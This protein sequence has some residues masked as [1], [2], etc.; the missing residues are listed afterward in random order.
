M[1]PKNHSWF[2]EKFN[3]IDKYL[4]RMTKKKEKIKMLKSGAKEE[5]QRHHYYPYRNK[6]DYRWK[7]YEQLYTNKL[8]NK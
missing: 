7:Y 8:D 1:D 4:A 2:F 6:K 5:W 3:K